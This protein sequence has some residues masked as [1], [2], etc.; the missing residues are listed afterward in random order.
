[1]LESLRITD[2]AC[3]GIRLAG[4]SP[5]GAV[6]IDVGLSGATTP[7]PTHVEPMPASIRMGLPQVGTNL[8]AQWT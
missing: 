7:K 1:M 5:E 2:A 8:P 4:L 3:D 6:L